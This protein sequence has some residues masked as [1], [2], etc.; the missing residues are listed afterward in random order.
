[1]S[2]SKNGSQLD[3]QTFWNNKARTFPRYSPGEDNYEARVLAL[4]RANGVVFPGARI[5]DVGCG[6]GLYTLRLAQEAREVVA[7]DF[8][9]A[10]LAILR[11]DARQLGIQ[12]LKII[13]ADW[14]S[15]A[16][17]GQFDVVFCSMCPALALAGGFDKLLAQRAA[18]VVYLGWNGLLRSEVQ[19]GLYERYQISPKKFDSST[20]TRAILEE[21]GL[22][23]QSIPVEGTWRLTYAKEVLLDSVLTNL[24]DYGVEPDL[25]ELAAYLEKFRQP[26]GQYLEITD[27][28]ILMI[29]WK[30]L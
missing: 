17:P 12:N 30:N 24:H 27:Y 28:K 25:G 7:V 6:A 10:M 5:L 19:D 16:I 9:E 22:Q 2:A 20:R 23:Y 29:L 4:A 15:V 26:D 21:K 11:E 8:S 3:P 13:Q 1:M 14:L 18:Q